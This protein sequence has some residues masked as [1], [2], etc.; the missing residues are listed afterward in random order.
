MTEFFLITAHSW[1]TNF[2]IR[3]R[4]GLLTHLPIQCTQIRVR[5]PLLRLTKIFSWFSVMSQWVNCEHHDASLY[6]KLSTTVQ[7]CRSSTCPSLPLQSRNS[8]SQHQSALC[9]KSLH[10]V[11]TLTLDQFL[12]HQ[13]CHDLW[14]EPLSI[15]SYILHSL[16][17]HPPFLSLTSLHS[18]HQHPPPQPS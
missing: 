16:T 1:L 8:G 12:S 14:N 17:L 4:I 2:I 9:L 3:L 5:W 11:I 18:V 15:T 10:P 6:Q 13:S 7:S